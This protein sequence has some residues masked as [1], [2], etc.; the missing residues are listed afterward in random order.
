M[1]CRILASDRMGDGDAGWL[2]HAAMVDV[3]ASMPGARLRVFVSHTGELASFPAGRS[4]V[5]AGLDGIVRAGCVPVDMRYFAAR[6]GQPADYCR[7]QVQGCDLYVAVIGCTPS[8]VTKI[9]W[10]SFTVDEGTA[11]SVFRR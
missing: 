6:D 1:G 11:P 4:F 2:R 7:Q 9:C 8:G 3:T 5:Q 10:P